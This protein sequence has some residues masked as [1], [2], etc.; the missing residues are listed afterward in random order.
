MIGQTISHYKI[1]EKLGKGGMGVVYKAEDTKLK[2]NVALKFISAERFEDDDTRD[3]FVNE[4][5]TVASL[6]HSNICTV[7]EIDEV[8]EKIFIAMEL[9]EGQS[10]KQMIK[11]GPLDVDTA[12]SIAKQVSQGLQEAHNKGIVHR[13]IKSANIMITPKGDAKIMDFGIA[14]TTTETQVTETAT[15]VGT[16]A[17]MSPEQ[18]QG[19]KVD[20]RSDVWS[21]GVLLY[22]MLAGQLPFIGK[23]DQFILYS[24]LNDNPAPLTS[25]RKGIP[26]ELEGITR[27]CL[28]KK[29]ENRYQ[30]ALDLNIDLRRLTRDITD[31]TA[32][33]TSVRMMFPVVAKKAFLKWALPLGLVIVILLGV[34]LIPTVRESL[35]VKMGLRPLPE[36]K[37]LAVLPFSVIGGDPD[38]QLKCDGLVEIVTNKLTQ[39]ESLQESLQVIPPNDVRQNNISSSTDA[40]KALGV[41]LVVDG[42][43]IPVLD[44]VKLTL[45]L[46]NT[47]PPRQLRAK[48]VE[49]PIASFHL[50]NDE[51]VN[52]VVEMLALEIKPEVGNVLAEGG[53]DNP[54]ALIYYAEGL[55]ILSQGGDELTLDRAITKLERSIERDPTFAMAHV[56][57]GLTCWK[58]WDRTKDPTWVEKAHFH[59][60]EALRINDKLVPAHIAYGITLLGTGEYKLAAKNLEKA[61]ELDAAN[62]EAHRELARVYM[63]MGRMDEAE[64][65]FKIAIDLKQNYWRGHYSL[66]YLYLRQG[67]YEEAEEKFKRVTELK[68][69]DKDGF[70]LLGVIYYLQRKMDPAIDAF[71]KAMELGPN[72]T[73]SS[74]L[75]TIYYFHKQNY[76]KAKDMYEKALELDKTSYATHGNLADACRQLGE[77]EKAEIS[78]REAITLAEKVLLVNP[79]DV[80]AMS[81]VARYYARTGDEK[82]ALARINKALSVSPKNIEVLKGSVK[83]FETVGR[84]DLAL[85]YTEEYLNKTGN[86]SEIEENP[87]LSGLRKDPKYIQIIKDFAEK[88]SEK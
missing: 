19:G 42:K 48:D 83:V 32:H 58:K 24:I 18:I 10:L 51:A 33:I 66:G 28:E 61:V 63:Q 80:T 49:V 22:E 81:M 85:K 43:I 86:L 79:K 40:W 55:G 59:C 37:F 72:Y 11:A 26:L 15:L 46:S 60:Q 1:L 53:S 5:Q 69:E 16:L 44:N 14:K 47:N 21:L 50:L 62:E 77:K 56:D 35:I 70:N 67:K 31:G 87:D 38:I 45:S 71:E 65:E 78:Y 27:K 39:L 6:N 68:T 29:S 9:V 64:R 12:I 17:Y 84:R 73:A 75:G 57:L 36:T 52:A 20:A 76:K 34:F 7:Y 3:R 74:N 88:S 23:K 4:A 41:N 30:T 8:D 2:R 25:V 54:D 82:T 13:D